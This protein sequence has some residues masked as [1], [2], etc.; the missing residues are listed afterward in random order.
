MKKKKYF[1]IICGVVL[2]IVLAR[3]FYQ[4]YTSNQIYHGCIVVQK[5]MGDS[6]KYL[7][8][9]PNNLSESVLLDFSNY[10]SKLGRS[11]AQPTFDD[12]SIYL[13]ACDLR[14]KTPYTI[15]KIMDGTIEILPVELPYSNRQDKS[16]LSL[17]DSLV[18]TDDENVFFISKKD[19]KINTAYTARKEYTNILPYQEG[20]ITISKNNE[21]VYLHDD[22]QEIFFRMPLNYSFQGWF[23]VGE[24][25]LV[26]DRDAG[27]SVIINLAGEKIKVLGTQPYSVLG[28]DQ[29][30]VL[31]KMLPK[32]GGG[33]T[34]L[35]F[36]Y[37]WMDLI[38]A[39]HRYCLYPYIYNINTKDIKNL[40]MEV[41]FR[42]N[43]W[44]KMNFDKEYLE[45][46]AESLKSQ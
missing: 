25:F 31:L 37:D 27:E 32:G 46:I 41:G 18:I 10:Q 35:D 39:E 4:G 16:L 28:N 8:V 29:N 14:K 34:I 36:E 21:V 19:Y 42:F 20:A 17:K 15:I 30:T 22:K 23:Q 12:N 33:V 43:S 1:F 11:L 13:I 38:R 40:N 26:Y 3:Y 44:Q 24:N 6:G 45:K 7:V 5:M 9:N 2:F